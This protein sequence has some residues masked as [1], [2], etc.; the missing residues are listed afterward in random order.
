MLTALRP[1]ELLPLARA[2]I[3]DLR[4]RFR[5]HQRLPARLGT[6]ALWL[7]SLSL[8]GPLKLAGL[9]LVGSLVAPGLLWLD[10]G[11][12]EAGGETPTVAVLPPPPEG[13]PRAALASRFGLPESQLFRARHAA[14][15]TV[16]HD[17]EGQ[18]VNLEVHG[19][20]ASVRLI[21]HDAHPVG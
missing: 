20:P 4:E 5:W 21:R 19:A 6:G 13:P 12:R 15:C 10:R 18:I 1:P 16:H 7:G 8:V 11:R 3:V 2:P 14:I 17:A 9:V